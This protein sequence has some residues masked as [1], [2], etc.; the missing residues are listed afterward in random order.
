MQRVWYDGAAPWLSLLLL[1]LSCLFRGIVALRRTAYRRGWLSSLRV[2]RAVIVVGNITVGG[3]GKTPFTIWLAQWLQARGVRVGIVLRGYGGQSA[4]WPRE[5]TPQTPWEEVGDEA[6]LLA[7][8]SGAI[9]VAGPDRVADARRAIELGADIVISDDGLQHY[10]LARDCEIAVI[11]ARRG[12]GNGRLLPAGPLREPAGRLAEVDLRVLRGGAADSDSPHRA[13]GTTKQVSV[14]SMLREAVSL[15]T[16]ERRP[17][18]SF[19]GAPVHAVAAIGHPAAFFASLAALGLEVEGRALA[20]HARL[21]SAA[22]SF[23]DQRPVLMTEKDA[24]KCRA[25]ADARH[26]A[27]RMDV[28]MSA[29][30]EAVVSGIV[31][32][33]ATPAARSGS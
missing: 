15:R 14:G 11:D 3:T 2:E 30:D 6:V 12:L 33:L 23:G 21:A 31:G 29:A 5:V 17:V 9:V 1:P 26:W 18:E 19:A 7:Q 24:V 13:A 8:R 28:Q 25:I 20:D 27:V 10:R 4:Q 22:I 16:G 32:R